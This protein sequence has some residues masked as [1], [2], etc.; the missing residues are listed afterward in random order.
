MKTHVDAAVGGALMGKSAKETQ[1]LIEKMVANNYQWA[2]AGMFEVDTL[3]MLKC[4][5]G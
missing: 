2:N 4:Q 1:R 3:N 5:N